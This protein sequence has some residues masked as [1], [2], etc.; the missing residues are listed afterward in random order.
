MKK[1]A[2]VV[3]A[4][5]LL[6]AGVNLAITG[7][8]PTRQAAEELQVKIDT[9]QKASTIEP[10]DP[11]Q[12]EVSDLEL[13]SYVLFS[14]K[15]QIPARVD[16][17]DVQLTRDTVAADTRLTFASNSTRNPVIDALIA[18]T[19]DVFLKGK[20]S[21][22]DGMGKFDLEQVRVDG[23]PVPKSVIQALVERYVNP[24]HPDV[25]LNSPFEM[26]W[27]IEN[28]TIRQDKASIVY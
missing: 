12:M 20:F 16:S 25:D 2:W 11:E 15:E 6:G 26:P 3:V 9:I 4:A 19:H 17:F 7:H 5:V 8:Q 28:L 21:A 22:R 13:E 23:I 14:L 1:I 27:G 18:G 10:R 24:K